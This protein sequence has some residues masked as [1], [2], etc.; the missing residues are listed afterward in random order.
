MRIHLSRNVISCSHLNYHLELR[1]ENIFVFQF[2][3][4]SLLEKACGENL[5]GIYYN[6]EKCNM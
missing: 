1:S 5:S 4:V 2:F 3:P 6:M